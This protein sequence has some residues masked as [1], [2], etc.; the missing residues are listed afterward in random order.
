MANYNPNKVKINRS[1]SYEELAAV[2]GVHKNTVATWVKNGLPCLKEMR[3]YLILGA[4]AKQYLQAQRQTKKQVCKPGE[5]FCVRCKKPVQPLDNRVQYFP[6]TAAK[7]CLRGICCTCK[8]VVN[9]FVGY[10]S[11]VGYAQIFDLT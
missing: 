5:L 11:L 2:Y 8:R 10:S 9:K 1:Y 6:L 4:D 7:G 3:P